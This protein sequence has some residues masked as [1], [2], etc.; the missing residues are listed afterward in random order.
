M[1]VYLVDVPALLLSSLFLHYNWCWSWT[2][3]WQKCHFLPHLAFSALPQCVCLLLAQ[4]LVYCLCQFTRFGNIDDITG[5][6]A[7]IEFFLFY[8]LIPLDVVK[9]FFFFF[10]HLEV[11]SFWHLWRQFFVVVAGWAQECCALIALG[12]SLWRRRLQHGINVHSRNLLC[13]CSFHLLV[14]CDLTFDLRQIYIFF[15]I[16]ILR[17]C[18]LCVIYIKQAIFSYNN[19]N[20]NNE[21]DNDAHIHTFT[22]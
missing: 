20:N 3:S 4:T 17:H 2:T 13:L 18:R 19:N 5:I 10:K 9:W 6:L 7:V 8:R 21:I 22:H 14:H 12:N 11:I 16:I 1:S 15:I